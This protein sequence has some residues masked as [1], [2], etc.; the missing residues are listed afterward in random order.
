M[1]GETLVSGLAI[2]SVY[3]LMGM[4]L[5]VVFKVTEILNFAQGQ[6]GMIGAYVAVGAIA[7]GGGL[8]PAI[9]LGVAAALLACLGI[10]RIPVKALVVRGIGPFGISIATFGIYLLLTGMAALTWGHMARPFPSLLGD[11]RVSVLG[12]AASLDYLTILAAALVVAGV[13]YVYYTHTG[14]GL[15]ARAMANDAVA[16]QLAGV[17]A[18]R[19]TAIAWGLGGVIS[20]V[21]AVTVAPL[22]GASVDM[23]FPFL[24]KGMVAAVIGGLVSVPGAILG[25][26]LLGLSESVAG[27]LFRGDIRD[28]VAVVVLMVALLLRPEGLFGV[29]RTRKV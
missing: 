8:A 23:M 16:A 15:A 24:L 4:S 12:L 25:G 6:V 2:G 20:G 18:R 9:V 10:Y 1:D 21:A 19:A 13:T 11:R 5:L 27:S 7:M 28:S 17:D 29:Y 26:L 14:A 22:T 3:A